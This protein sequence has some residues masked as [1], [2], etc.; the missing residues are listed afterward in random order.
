MGI[1]ERKVQ[2][3]ARAKYM[4]DHPGQFPDSVMRPHRGC[5]ADDRDLAKGVQPAR[6]KG[7]WE[8]GMLGGVIASRLG[9]RG[10]MPKGYDL[11]GQ[12]GLKPMRDSK[13]RFLPA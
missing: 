4:A 11:E 5:G 1:A 10:N 13:G 9:F 12:L 8:R 3:Q 2:D 7:A 6:Q